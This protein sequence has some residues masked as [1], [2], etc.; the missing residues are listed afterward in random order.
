MTGRPTITSVV[1]PFATA[2]AASTFCCTGRDGVR[3]RAKTRRV[4]LELDLQLRNISPNQGQGAQYRTPPTRSNETW[5]MDFVHDQ[6]ATGISFAYSRSSIL[7]SRFS[8]AL[9]PRFTFRGNDV[10]LERAHEEVGFPA[11]I[12]AASPCRAILT[13]GHTSAA[14]VLA[15]FAF[16]K[17]RHVD[18]V[19]P[20]VG[21][22]RR[23]ISLPTVDLPRPLSSTRQSVSPRA[24]EKLMPSTYAPPESACR[25]S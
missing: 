24:I 4:Y 14:P 16:A 25:G 5:A 23:R 3:G 1:A 15:K 13:C 20:A 19:E 12:R 11:S 18:A 22:V 21:W 2:T 8:P 17:M 10:V 9:Q 6:L 7:T